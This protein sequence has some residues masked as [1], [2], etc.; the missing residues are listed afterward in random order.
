M[1][2]FGRVE[3]VAGLAVYLASEAASFVNGAVMTVDGGFLA[4]G[5]NQ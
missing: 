2:R 4:S 1:K 3:E 5:V